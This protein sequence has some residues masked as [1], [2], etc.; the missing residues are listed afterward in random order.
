MGKVLVGILIFITSFFVIAKVSVLIGMLIL[1]WGK[2]CIIQGLATWR[3]SPEVDT[4][5]R[6]MSATE[7]KHMRIAHNRAAINRSKARSQSSVQLSN[8]YS[9]S[10]LSSNSYTSDGDGVVINPASGLVMN[11]GYGGFDSEGNTYGTDSHHDSNY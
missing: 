1:I 3:D 5:R 9:T 11:G 10:N 7:Q 4:Y 8:S 6:P 2:C